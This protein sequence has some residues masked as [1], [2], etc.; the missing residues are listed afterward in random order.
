MIMHRFIQAIS[1]ILLLVVLGNAKASGISDT[2]LINRIMKANHVDEILERP[3]TDIDSINFLFEIP[4]RLFSLVLKHPKNSNIWNAIH[5]FRTITDAGLTTDFQMDCFDALKSNNHIYYDR[6]M[7]GDDL[8]LNRML[9]AMEA[10]LIDEG[11]NIIEQ[12][13]SNRKILQMTI[14]KIE[15]TDVAAFDL[16]KAKRHNWFVKEIRKKLIWR[17]KTFKELFIDSN[18]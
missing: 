7:E 4:D 5:H 3:S 1:I 6:F 14:D 13:K 10:Y 8:A 2:E 9:D 11:G 15:K 12:E 18:R 16:E 17:E